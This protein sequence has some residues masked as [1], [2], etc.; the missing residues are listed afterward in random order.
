MTTMVQNDDS[1]RKGR[2]IAVF[3]AGVG[4][5]WIFVI[6]LGNQYEWSQRTRALFDLIVL[7]GFG[8]GLWQGIKLWRARRDD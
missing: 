3:L 2:R 6:E 1:S 5:F 8:F 7:A 4:I